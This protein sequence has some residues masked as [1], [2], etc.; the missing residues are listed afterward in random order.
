MATA[1]FVVAPAGASQGT[2][3]DPKVPDNSRIAGVDTSSAA[4]TAWTGNGAYKGW[5]VVMGP[6]PTEAAAKA[7]HPPA[8]LRALLTAGQLGATVAA[9]SAIGSG[10]TLPGPTVSNPLDWLSNIGQFFTALTQPNL[11][12]RVAKVVLGGVMVVAGLIKLTGTDKKVYG[13]AGVAAQRLPGV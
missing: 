9:G 13:L 6:F 8:G 1:W 5:Q 11:W 7:A 4:Y 2:F 10:P 3:T 12:L